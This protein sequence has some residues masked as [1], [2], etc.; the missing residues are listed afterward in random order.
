M[1]SSI[2]RKIPLLVFGILFLAG[3]DSQDTSCDSRSTITSI[4]KTFG[5]DLAHSLI[6][7]SAIGL[8]EVKTVSSP[9]PD[10]GSKLHVC[11][12]TLVLELPDT[13]KNKI[14]ESNTAALALKQPGMALNAGKLEEKILFFSYI[15]GQ[16][17]IA[18][19]FVGNAEDKSFDRK[20]RIE[21]RLAFL[22][23]LLPPIEYLLPQKPTTGSENVITSLAASLTKS[24]RDELR[25]SSMSKN[26]GRQYLYLF[27]FGLSMGSF[28]VAVMLVSLIFVQALLNSPNK[29]PILVAGLL[30]FMFVGIGISLYQ[31]DSIMDSFGIKPVWRVKTRQDP[32]FSFFIGAICGALFL[33]TVPFVYVWRLIKAALESLKHRFSTNIQQTKKIGQ[34]SSSV[35]K[36]RRR[37]NKSRRRL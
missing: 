23:K 7:I 33:W 15:N 14:G 10:D 6:S 20:N 34:R 31:F 35:K 22:R 12:A 27:F 24:E 37:K 8:K 9:L 36:A 19:D 13:L 28:I 3:C 29:K 16:S 26:K 2:I 32:T 5:N 21:R 30:I 4:Q 11:E 1:L 25:W 17:E 18:V